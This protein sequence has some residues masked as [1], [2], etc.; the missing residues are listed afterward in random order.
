MKNATGILVL[1][2]IGSAAPAQSRPGLNDSG[3]CVSP[4]ARAGG[5]PCRPCPPRIGP[6]DERWL[7]VVKQYGQGGD[8]FTASVRERAERDP[9]YRESDGYRND[10]RASNRDRERFNAMREVARIPRD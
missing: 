5:M 1:L 8:A 4:C 3:D 2:V 10:V 7:E 9:S 6:G